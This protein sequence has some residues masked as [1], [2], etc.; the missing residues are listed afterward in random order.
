MK[1]YGGEH[2]RLKFGFLPTARHRGLDQTG[3]NWRDG[4]GGD[5][6]QDIRCTRR[7]FHVD[8]EQAIA[9]QFKLSSVG[10]A[11]MIEFLQPLRSL[12]Q[13]L[14]APYGL[15]LSVNMLSTFDSPGAAAMVHVVPGNLGLEPGRAY[16]IARNSDRSREVK[17]HATKT[18]HSPLHLLRWMRV[19][20][21][22][23]SISC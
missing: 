16:S 2:Q 7:S 1:D 10:E 11:R 17:N 23:L 13:P 12:A 5:L 9:Y 18:D 3:Q 4:H 8:C 19:V 22:W 20:P 15:D 14:T 6:V 21:S